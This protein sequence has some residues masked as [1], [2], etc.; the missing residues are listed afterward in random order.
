MRFFVTRS[1]KQFGWLG[2]VFLL[3][4]SQAPRRYSS[5]CA[6]IGKPMPGRVVAATPVAP[7]PK[8]ST[9]EPPLSLTATPS[10][11]LPTPVVAP[12][13]E[14]P[15]LHRVAKTERTTVAE[16]SATPEWRGS[17]VR[18]D[19]ASKSPASDVPITVYS[20]AADYRWL[21]G[22]LERGRR[23]NTWVLRY[24]PEEVNDHFG[25]S[26]TLVLDEA[27]TIGLTAGQSLRVEGALMDPD[28]GGARPG[29]RV[30]AAKAV[31][32]P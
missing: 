15:E 10:P 8:I 12:P 25:G 6:S 22:V 23:R 4:C 3:G 17:S 2:L 13:E 31:V 29:Y 26:V 16:A 11:V 24:A 5:C 18:A 14:V 27:D 9:T 1:W 32:R 20:H 19:R 30:T 21:S 28:A 7:A